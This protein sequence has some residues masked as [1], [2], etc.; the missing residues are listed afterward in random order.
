MKKVLLVLLITIACW[1]TTPPTS[2]A[3]CPR[4]EVIFARGT[5]EPPGVG[6]T[7]QEFM[8]ALN[9]K[10]GPVGVYAVLPSL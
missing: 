1:F 5:D 9:H 2:A 7:G 8:T 3:N 10:I 4:V 6:E